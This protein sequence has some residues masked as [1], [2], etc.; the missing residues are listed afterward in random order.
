MTSVSILKHELHEEELDLLSRLREVR[1]RQRQQD[2]PTLSLG[3][4]VADTVAAVVGSWQFIIIQSALLLIWIALNIL[5]YVA[6][7]I[8][9][10][11]SSSISCCPSRRP[12][13]TDH[14]DEPKPPIDGRS[15]EAAETDS[16]VNLKAELEIELLHHKLDSL[17]EIEV[18]KLIDT[19]RELQAELRLSQRPDPNSAGQGE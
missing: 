15:R 19:V 1:R 16:K 12:Y 2:R 8:P 10:P 7:G 6:H 3:N 17:R 11:S 14:H 13:G 5:A 18:V 9:I 4:R